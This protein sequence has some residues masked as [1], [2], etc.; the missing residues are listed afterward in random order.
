MRRAAW[1][2]LALLTAGN[3]V[4]AIAQDVARAVNE[5]V[6]F[7]ALAPGMRYGFMLNGREVVRPAEG[8][9]VLLN[10]SPVSVSGK[11]RC[12]GARCEIEGRSA[13]GEHV[14]LTVTVEPHHVAMEAETEQA[15]AE[16]LF[17]T[18]GA[19]PG[20]GLADHAVEK[21]FR[22]EARHG[23]FDTDVTGFADD[24]MIAGQGNARLESNFVIYPRQQFA[25]L[26]VHPGVKVVRSAEREIVQ[27]VAKGA[28]IGEGEHRRVVL[29]YFFGD[30]HEIYA[31]YLKVRRAARYEVLEPKYVAFGVGWEA[32]GALG[33]DTNQQ[34]VIESVDRYLKLG[35]PLKWAVIGSGFWPQEPDAMH[36]TT[37]F[38]YWNRMKYPDAAAM[39]KHF[40]DEGL[41]VLFGLRIT[42]IVGGPYSAEGVAKGYFLK[43]EDGQ[44]KVFTGAWPKLPYYL[45]DSHNQ[46]A[47]EWYLGLAN[48][49]REAG[50]KGW[51]EDFY[52]YGKFDL[53]DDKVDPINDRLMAEGDMVIERNGYLS[54]NGDLHRI[55]DFNYEQDQDRGP[56]NAL[57]LAYSGFPFVYPDIVG[58][59][60]GEQ[61]FSTQ[62]TPKMQVYMRRNAQWAAL[63]SSMGMGEPPWSFDPQ[64]ADVMLASAKLHATIAPYLYSNARRAVKD[65]FPW[66]MTPLPLAFPQDG[67]VYGRENSQVR[68]YEWMIGDA[69]LATPLYGNDYQSA[70]ARDVVLP[71]GK[72]MEWD[73]G[74]VR[75][76]GR[77]LKDYAL[78]TG[79]TPL[80]VGGS[81]VVL[82]DINGTVQVCVYPVGQSG[83]VEL[84]LPN[85]PLAFSV[86]VKD[87]PVGAWG[88]VSVMDAE[89]GAV[90]TQVQGHAIA[91]VPRAGEAYRVAVAR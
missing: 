11:P 57:A 59:T 29:H 25:E 90:P 79:K 58:G 62:R 73:S 2:V 22:T 83:Q 24:H 28:A 77:V 84:T 4:R 8:A 3:M 43:G 7:R 56:V 14:R 30:P 35:Y 86:G 41:R 72:W 40:A 46:A 88:R 48:R 39:T 44:A 52:G 51:K 74:K 37:S 5:G 10:G 20:F 9:G 23:A 53:R 61:H 15:N 66:T 76:G 19:A 75:D 33:W 87:A 34:T 54:S 70:N 42:F 21:K 80:F 63:H 31:E 82:E 1:L 85:D 45:L 68:G 49:W 91:F 18:A 55:N 6:E 81:G 65:G 78:P 71:A 16:L 50:V 26:L 38:G 36:E 47:L 69:L 60:F 64:T 67:S 17:V 27:G 89:G 12:A 13:A 32:F